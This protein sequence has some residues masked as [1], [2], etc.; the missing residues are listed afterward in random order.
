MQ[1]W[2]WLVRRVGVLLLLLFVL[3]F[4]TFLLFVKIPS[5]PAGFLV[6]VQH[7]SPQEIA[8]ARHLLG[9]DQPIYVQYA[10]WVWRLGHLDFGRD[11]LTAG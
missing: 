9:A 2:A 8:H 6:D 3:T 11:W 5:Q 1:T 7:S 10:K 4:V